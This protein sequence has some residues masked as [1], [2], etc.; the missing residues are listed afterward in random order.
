MATATPNSGKVSHDVEM[1]ILLDNGS[2]LPM[3]CTLEYDV[4]DPFAVS[5]TFRS[6]EGTVTW[7]FGRELLLAGMSGPSGIG[8][9]RVEPL[10]R[11]G[12]AVMRMDLTSPSGSAVIESPL[13]RIKEFLEATLDVM[14]EGSEWQYLNFDT[15]LSDLLNG[16]TA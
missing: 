8:D 7:V 10:Q 3:P 4:R 11:H 12:R 16:G 2:S 1:R 15:A 9:I 6:A 5:A 13:H 14:P